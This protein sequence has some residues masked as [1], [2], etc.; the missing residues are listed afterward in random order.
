MYTVFLLRI[1][2]CLFVYVVFRLL[3]TRVSNTT[4]IF[5]FRASQAFYFTILLVLV[6]KNP[7]PFI[8]IYI[9]T[10]ADHK[11]QLSGFY[12]L[13]IILLAVFKTRNYISEYFPVCVFLCSFSR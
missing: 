2:V 1:F 10:I 4:S 11:V 8:N 5:I 12:N 3:F 7:L 6:L 13:F 9:L